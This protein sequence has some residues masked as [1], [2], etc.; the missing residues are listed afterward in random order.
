MRH[1]KALSVATVV[2]AAALFGM[3]LG[4]ALDLT[5]NAGAER[6][7]QAVAVLQQAPMA[8]P[9][10]AVLAERV[11][12]SVVSVDNTNLVERGE[13]RGF[14]DPFQFFFGPQR[15]DDEEREAIPRRSSGSGFFI[16]STGEILTNYHV[17]EG[18]DKLTVELVDGDRLEVEVVGTDP[19]TDLALL[20]VVDPQREFA[21]LPLGN[22]ETLRVGEWVMAVGN[23]LNM[24]HTV[25]VGVVSAKGRV[26]GLSDRS[27]ENY[28]QTDAA[29]NFGNSGG[30]LVNIRG[31]VVGIATAIN[32]RGQNLGFA[33]P[34]ETVTGILDQLRADGRVQRGYLGVTIQE[35][36]ST[37][38]EAFGLESRDGA[39][40]QEVLPKKAADKAGVQPG[41]VIIS[42]DGE[43]IES[44]R[45][46]IDEV[47]STPPGTEVTLGIIRN[48]RELKLDVTLE[49]RRLSE[50]DPTADVGDE[51]EESMLEQLGFGIGE[52]TSRT[53]QM[54]DLDE[55]ANGV[56]VTRVQ[57]L[58]PAADQGLIRGDVLVEANGQ[59]LTSTEDLL[60]IVSGMDEGS[61]LRLYVYRARGDASFFV[62][63]K[64]AGDE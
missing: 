7:E 41:D 58:S 63:L 55:D 9:D 44:S 38:Q 49:E 52:L 39:F 10:F 28:I 1:V 21:A 64:I 60:K 32:A 35:V 40:V 47:S 23:P 22:A 48:G 18:A 3:I 31:E 36:D 62:I 30:P 37:M 54:L 43:R 11:V 19:P 45:D 57:P 51:D 59:E 14:R 46:L 33:V 20:K 17:V 34:V 24:D 8:A 25:T 6:T 16:S 13:R 53:R 5:Q 15:E 61:Y 4:G 56:L 50:E 12:P 27:F 29:I 26:L 42:V 2:V